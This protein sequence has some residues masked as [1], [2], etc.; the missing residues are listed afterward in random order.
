MALWWIGNAVLLLVIAPVVVVLLLRVLGTAK[1]VR[2]TVGDI[3]GVGATMVDDLGSVPELIKTESYVSQTTQG[4]VRQQD[5][6][7]YVATGWG[8]DVA[9]LLREASWVDL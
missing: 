6:G 4:L 2:R 8:D 3:A 7:A 1:T 5:R 9:K